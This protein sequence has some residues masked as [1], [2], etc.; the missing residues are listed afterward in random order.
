SRARPQ[1]TVP[2]SSPAPPPTRTDGVRIRAQVFRISTFSYALKYS[3]A[4]RNRE[5]A[6]GG[7]LVPTGGRPRAPVFCRQGQ[8]WTVAEIAPRSLR[9]GAG[10]PLPVQAAK[11]DLGHCTGPQADSLRRANRLPIA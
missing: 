2:C 8:A 6:G 10:Y 9:H 4:R 3:A 11:I 5:S 1:S 7:A